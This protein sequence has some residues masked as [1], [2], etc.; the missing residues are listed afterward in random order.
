MPT[1]GRNTD[2]VILWGGFR[3]DLPGV[4]AFSASQ[5]V[6]EIRQHPFNNDPCAA[7]LPA[8]WRGQVTFIRD[9][10]S[11]D[12]LTASIEA[13]FLDGC[14]VNTGALFQYI[15]EPDG[16]QST[17]EFAGLTFRAENT[18]AYQASGVVRQTLGFTASRRRK[19]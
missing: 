7:D 18:G 9:A 12:A 1:I 14:V 11:F 2:I 16:S 17:F 19:L 5:I 4:Q 13:N 6:D 10:G 15:R 3:V 8:G